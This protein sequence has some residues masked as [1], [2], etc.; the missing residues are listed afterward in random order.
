MQSFR[1]QLKGWETPEKA[2]FAVANTLGLFPGSKDEPR[3]FEAV[4]ALFYSDN[5]LSRACHNTLD[6]LIE[7]GALETAKGRIRWNPT[8]KGL[9]LT[10][11]R[12]TEFNQ[13]DDIMLCFEALKDDPKVARME[14]YE[15]PLSRRMGFR[16]LD[17]NGR[18][19]ELYL[20]PLAVIQCRPPAPYSVERKLI[21][22]PNGRQTLFAFE[23]GKQ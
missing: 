8:F 9:P 4:K 5:P 17:A 1:K 23:R 2:C 14:S 13:W 15:E 21:Q 3:L 10:K 6:S 7:A 16:T 18:G 11:A 12:E 20:L 19:M 22:T